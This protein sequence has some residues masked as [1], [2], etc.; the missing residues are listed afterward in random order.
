MAQIPLLKLDVTTMNREARELLLLVGAE[1]PP[2][3]F[4]AD[5]RART[6]QP[7]SRLVGKF[8]I[9]DLMERLRPFS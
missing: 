5:T 4:V 8:M 7:G 6:E 1:G 9:D 3:L 2:T